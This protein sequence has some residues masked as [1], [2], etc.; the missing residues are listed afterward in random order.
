[1]IMPPNHALQRTAAG[2]HQ[3]SSPRDP[4]AVYRDCNRRAPSPT[5]PILGR[6]SASHDLTP[7]TQQTKIH[8]MKTIITLL[9]ILFGILVGFIGCIALLNAPYQLLNANFTF[10]SGGPFILLSLILG[11]L[12]VWGAWHLIRG[13]RVPPPAA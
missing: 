7:T 12:M 5:S 9:R 4:D 13:A 6:E 11:S 3:R 10:T 8:Q 1:M 2:R